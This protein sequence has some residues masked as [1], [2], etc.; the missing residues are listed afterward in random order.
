[1][2]RL[3]V[4][5]SALAEIDRIAIIC[6]VSV[7]LFYVLRGRPP[8]PARDNP[9][10]VCAALPRHVVQRTTVGGCP[11]ILNK[12]EDGNSCEAGEGH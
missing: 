8:G 2:D 6:G 1:M 9:A 3:G 4:V 11:Q 7:K 12:F 5:E 10:S